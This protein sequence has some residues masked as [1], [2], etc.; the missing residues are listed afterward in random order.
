MS[1]EKRSYEDDLGSWLLRL[2][3][4]SRIWRSLRANCGNLLNITIIPR[5]SGPHFGR[6]MT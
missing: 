3:A 2:R 5:N 6:W 1:D 4:A